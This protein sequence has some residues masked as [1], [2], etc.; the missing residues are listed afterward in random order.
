MTPFLPIYFHLFQEKVQPLEQQVRC[1]K[2]QIGVEIHFLTK[3][4]Y[5]RI[6]SPNPHIS[7]VWALNDNAKELIKGLKAENFDLIIDLHK[8]L[9]SLKFKKQL[10]QTLQEIEKV[11]GKE[12]VDR[13]RKQI[14]DILVK[15]ML[16]GLPHLQHNYRTCTNKNLPNNRQCF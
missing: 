9:R 3:K 2:Q 10:G 11:E 12:R 5:Q 15:T 16:V 14:K 6:L 7:K 8:N 4:S 1:L 13:L